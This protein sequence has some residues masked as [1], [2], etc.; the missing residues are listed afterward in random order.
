MEWRRSSMF[1]AACAAG[2]ASRAAAINPAA[3][4]LWKLPMPSL[5]RV[6]QPGREL[7]RT[8]RRAQRTS[9]QAYPLITLLYVTPLPPMPFDQDPAVAAMVANAEEPRWPYAVDAPPMALLPTHIGGHPRANGLSQNPNRPAV[10]SRR[11][12]PDNVGRRCARNVDD[13]GP[14]AV[15][16]GNP[17]AGFW[18][19]AWAI[20]QSR[21]KAASPGRTRRFMVIPWPLAKGLA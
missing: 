14:A 13:A 15:R 20:P 12:H 17:A 19:K 7:I 10:G 3:K 6:N 9:E 5:R 2:P 11:T 8:W 4:P 21:V 1:V 18:A 16:A